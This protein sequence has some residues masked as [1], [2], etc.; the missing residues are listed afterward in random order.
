MIQVVPMGICCGTL[1]GPDGR[2]GFVLL[3]WEGGDGGM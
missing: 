3:A 2:K 1:A